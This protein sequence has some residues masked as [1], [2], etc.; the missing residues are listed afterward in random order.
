MNTAMGRSHAWVKRGTEF[1]D[2]VPM[3]WGKNLTLYGAIRRSGWVVLNSAFASANGRSLRRVVVVQ[4]AA[5]AA[6]GRR[7]C[8]GQPQGA[9]RP[10]RA[11]TLRTPRRSSRVLAAVLTRLQSDRARVGPAEA[12][13]AQA[14]PAERARPQ[15]H[16]QAG[17][18]PHHRPPLPQLVHA[19]WLPVI[20]SGD[21]W[22]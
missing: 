22:G 8:D 12:A 7:P 21:L 5:E 4:P 15:T 1:V 18:L 3:N 14:R 11:T 9:S 2:R 6:Q 16:R 17:P 10:S 13:R 19:C 20:N